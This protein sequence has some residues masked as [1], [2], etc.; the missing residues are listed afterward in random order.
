MIEMTSHTNDKSPLSGVRG[1]IL[2]FKSNPFVDAPEDCYDYFPDGLVV[3]RDGR[4][5]DVGEYADVAPRHE[6]LSA[7]A[8]DRYEDA[9][10]MPGFIDCHTLRAKPDDRVFR[11]HPA[12]LAQPIYLP[13]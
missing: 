3:M 9:L 12:R 2:S 1:R 13:E 4:I 10:I 5:V 8:I 6:S 7:D 11:R